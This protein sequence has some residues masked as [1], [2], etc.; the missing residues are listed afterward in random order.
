M[1]RKDK[2]PPIDRFNRDR[3][4]YRWA[5]ACDMLKWPEYDVWFADDDDLFTLGPIYNYVS[6]NEFD[7][8]LPWHMLSTDDQMM[9]QAETLYT[10]TQQ[11]STRWLLEAYLCAD[12][13]RTKIAEVLRLEIDVVLAYEKA[14]FDVQLYI[15]DPIT[16]ERYVLVYTDKTAHDR[17]SKM[18]AFQHGKAI[19]DFI[20]REVFP[21]EDTEKEVEKICLRMYQHNKMRASVGTYKLKEGELDVALIN[22]RERALEISAAR[23]HDTQG[24]NTLTP[25][26]GDMANAFVGALTSAGKRVTTKQIEKR[27]GE[28]TAKFVKSQQMSADK[29]VLANM[30]TTLKN[31]R[32]AKKKE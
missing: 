17:D 18:V 1:R 8:E 15:H 21:N 11:S 10:Q 14:F 3:P 9:R 13:D 31:T 4:H 7:N 26:G 2:E 22:L 29:H 28:G 23:N 20:Y 12:I 27:A 16:F 25:G 30:V 19:Y 6:N 24:S 5:L 32:N